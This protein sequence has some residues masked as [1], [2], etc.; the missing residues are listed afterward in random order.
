MDAILEALRAGL[1]VLVTQFGLTLALLMIGAAIYMAITPFHEMALV[2]QG[3]TAAGV[4]LAGT[5]IS[6]AIPLGATLATSRL[7]L[8]IL[9]WGIVALVL[10]LVTFGIASL[11]IRGLRGMIEAGNL[12]AAWVLVGIQLAVAILNAGAMAG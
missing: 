10:Q 7:T 4:V 8:D 6:I 9:I 5:L 12:A 3:N 2:R 1:P 11:L